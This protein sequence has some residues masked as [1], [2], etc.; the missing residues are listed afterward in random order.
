MTATEL[1]VWGVVVHLLVDWLLQ[2]R[3]VAQNKHSLRRPAGYV[4]AGLHGVAMLLVFSPPAALAIAVAHLL[5][6]T[7][8]PLMWWA[9]VMSHDASPPMAQIVHVW[10]DQALHV[11][12]IAAVALLT[13]S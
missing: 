5:I 13:G 2:N 3:W 12:V 7:R 4:H 1:L 9:R 11:G 10:R 6:D 8:R